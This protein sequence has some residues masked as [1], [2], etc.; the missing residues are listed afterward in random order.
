MKEK[1]S[2]EK[3]QKAVT[4]VKAKTLKET[5]SSMYGDEIK[6]KSVKFSKEIADW[7]TDRAKYSLRSVNA[8]IF[9]ILTAAMIED[10]Q[11]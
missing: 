2:K 6:I 7:L 3:K 5:S 9:S 1:I 8:E 4:K 11:A 10:M